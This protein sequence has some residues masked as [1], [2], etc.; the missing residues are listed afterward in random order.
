MALMT[1]IREAAMVAGLR[2]AIA[3]LGLVAGQLG[4]STEERLAVVG[5]VGRALDVNSP[6]R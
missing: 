4:L 5:R 1:T 3:A 2:L 6:A